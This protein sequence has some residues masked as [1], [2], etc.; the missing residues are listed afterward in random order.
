MEWPPRRFGGSDGV[1]PIDHVVEPGGIRRHEDVDLW[2]I[3]HGGHRLELELALALE[4]VRDGP[5]TLPIRARRD[6]LGVQF[7]ERPDRHSPLVIL[8]IEPTR[9][10]LDLFEH[11]RLGQLD[12]ALPGLIL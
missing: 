7:R 9:V 11:D 6:L 1:D 8:P 3:E 10:R 4:Q 5:A 2:I 12:I